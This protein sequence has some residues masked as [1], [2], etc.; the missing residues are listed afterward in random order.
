VWH[1]KPR[2]QAAPSHPCSSR[3]SPGCLEASVTF[4]VFG[5]L[6]WGLNSVASGDP[7][8]LQPIQ[9]LNSSGF[10]FICLVF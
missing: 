7:G 10:L 6:T 5:L 1:T 3:E 9:H 2:A 4:T 8:T